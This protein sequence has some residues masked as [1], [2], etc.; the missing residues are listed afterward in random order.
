VREQKPIVESIKLSN[1]GFDVIA[2]YQRSNVVHDRVK[3]A[4]EK[5]V[6]LRDRLAKT[7]DEKERREQRLKEISEE[8]ARIR[9][10]LQ[11]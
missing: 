5:V 10:N 9:Q 2:I 8:Q 6:T 11:A 4:L 3:E 7:S 1:S